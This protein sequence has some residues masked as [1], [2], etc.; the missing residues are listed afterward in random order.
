MRSGHWHS[1]SLGRWSAMAG[2]SVTGRCYL[3][4]AHG[5][6]IFSAQS[7]CELIASVLARLC[8]HIVNFNNQERI[9][10]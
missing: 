4:C 2:P 7:A 3:L 8:R 6:V 9:H 1:L 10:V 5:T